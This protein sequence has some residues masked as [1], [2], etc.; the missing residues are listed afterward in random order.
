MH[1]TIFTWTHEINFSWQKLLK[2]QYFPN[3]RSKI[4]K[5]TPQEISL[6]KGFL[7]VLTNKLA[8]ISIF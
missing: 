4:Y 6:N 2:I 7:V 3:F 1:S 8:P 5:I